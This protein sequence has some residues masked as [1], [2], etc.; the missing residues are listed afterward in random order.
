MLLSMQSAKPLIVAGVIT[1]AAAAAAAQAAPPTATPV[2]H[3]VTCGDGTTDNSNAK[4][5]CGTHGGVKKNAKPKAAHVPSTAAASAAAA[6][7]ATKIMSPRDP[8]SP[9]KIMT[10][11]AGGI[12]QTTEMK[13]DKAA[14]TNAAGGVGNTAVE[15]EGQMSKTPAGGIG[16]TQV[17][18]GETA[19]KCKDGSYSKAEHAKDRCAANGG[20]AVPGAAKPTPP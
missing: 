2:P 3:T 8:A 9:T 10:P 19:V 4:S 14:Q 5:P 20:V 11:A 1:F 6:T 7:P 13:M 16:Q 18:K 12:G 17:I 15:K